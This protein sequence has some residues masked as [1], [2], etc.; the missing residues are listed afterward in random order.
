MIQVHERCR[1]VGRDE[2]TYH[3][4]SADMGEKSAPKY[5]IKV[6]HVFQIP[7]DK[8]YPDP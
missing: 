3:Y 4:I 2:R 5:I 8:T 6:T 1:A 7:F